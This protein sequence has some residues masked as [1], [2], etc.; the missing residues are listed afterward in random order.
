MTDYKWT[1]YRKDDVAKRL[2][3]YPW[4]FYFDQDGSGVF[5]H[6]TATD[7]HRD[8]SC[9]K[10]AREC[11]SDMTFTAAMKMVISG[12]GKPCQD[13][14]SEF[15]ESIDELEKDHLPHPAGATIDELRRIAEE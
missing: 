4:Q 15:P 6:H 10:E 3:Q 7:R 14:L 5:H 12:E 9:A 1:D 13:C 2:G 8:H 11:D